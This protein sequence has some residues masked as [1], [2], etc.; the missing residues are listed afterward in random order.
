M[1]S[2]HS[3]CLAWVPA[4]TISL[5]FL[6]AIGKI[7]IKNPTPTLRIEAHILASDIGAD[8]LYER[9]AGFYLSHRLRDER[10]FAGLDELKGQIALD[11]VE[12][13]RRLKIS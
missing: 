9:R 12:A 4:E 2:P 13:R 3:L 8:A 5:A 7:P 10:R 1:V 6:G 11:I